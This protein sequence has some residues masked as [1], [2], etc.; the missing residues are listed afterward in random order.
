MFDNKSIYALNKKDPDAIVYKD[1][2][3]KIIRFT[4]DDF[5]SDEEFVTLKKWSDENYRKEENRE[6]QYQKKKVSVSMV[7]E[8][9]TSVKSAEDEV[10]NALCKG[11]E[12]EIAV[13]VKEVMKRKL[14]ATQRRRYVKYYVHK[15][16][17]YEIA[18][19]EKV[20]FQAVSKSIKEAEKILKKIFR[21]FPKMG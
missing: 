14:T 21:N 15:R 17:L 11:E 12:F 2:D 4:S 8:I 3:G 10:E 1:A 6:Q 7:S 18:R 9:T 19:E 20:S 16:T 13:E 5:E